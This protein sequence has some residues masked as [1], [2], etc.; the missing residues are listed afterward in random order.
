MRPQCTGI[1]C[2]TGGTAASTLAGHAPSCTVLPAHACKLAHQRRRRAIEH[3]LSAQARTD[4]DPS[5]A[6]LAQGAATGFPGKV[7]SANKRHGIIDNHKVLVMRAPR[8]MTGV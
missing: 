6:R 3:G 5:I 2:N 7:E 8:R 4:I 1:V